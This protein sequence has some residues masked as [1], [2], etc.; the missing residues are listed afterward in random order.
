MGTADK[1]TSL[2]M[3]DQHGKMRS[4]LSVTNDGNVV[5]T[6]LDSNDKPRTVFGVDSKN[7]PLVATMDAKGEV[8]DLTAE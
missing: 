5:L 7:K 2:V 6:M 4:T 1:G 3:M 8:N